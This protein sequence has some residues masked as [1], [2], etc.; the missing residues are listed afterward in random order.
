MVKSVQYQTLR[1]SAGKALFTTF[2]NLAPRAARESS[3]LGIVGYSRGA[4]LDLL[5]RKKPY[6]DLF[7]GFRQVYATTPH[8]S[9]DASQNDHLSQTKVFFFL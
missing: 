6:V 1:K 3:S 5:N 9:S 7:E 8:P 2:P 4:T